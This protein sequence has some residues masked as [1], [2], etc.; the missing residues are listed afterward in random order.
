MKH[1]SAI[2]L[3]LFLLLVLPGKT[4]S[5][6]EDA[7]LIKGSYFKIT[8]GITLGPVTMEPFIENIGI[9]IVGE[10]KREFGENWLYGVSLEGMIPVAGFLLPVVKNA[11]FTAYF[12]WPL[13]K[14][15]LFLLPG[16]GL[17]G[18]L[19]IEEG[20]SLRAVPTVSANL[21]MLWQVSHN[22]FVEFSPLLIYPSRLNFPINFISPGGGTF[23][24]PIASVG[25][26]FSL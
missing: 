6:Q 3:L 16:V 2:V 18:N 22:A 8:S 15:R 7:P 13:I 25:L 10:Y 9:R 14:D 21:S 19:L 4:V 23:I 24:I 11:S 17:G 26:K 1:P 5:G 12:R 20:V